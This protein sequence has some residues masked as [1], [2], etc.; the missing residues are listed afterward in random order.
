MNTHHILRNSQ[1]DPNGK[2]VLVA[3]NCR[4]N[5]HGE[6]SIHV[7]ELMRLTSLSRRGVQRILRRL[8]DI[9][10]LAIVPGG[11]GDAP[12]LYV[13]LVSQRQR[14]GRADETP[15]PAGRRASLAPLASLDNTKALHAAQPINR[16]MNGR[17]G[18]A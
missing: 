1:A 10:E 2:L 11:S 4:A 8:E 6:A 17:D 12:S 5:D 3:I 13:V 7:R 9:G 18:A 15:A 16:V 14:Q